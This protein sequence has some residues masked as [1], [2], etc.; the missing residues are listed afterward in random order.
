MYFNPEITVYILYGLVIVAILSIAWA[1]WLEIRLK[2]L[3]KGTNGKSLEGVINSNKK[4]LE[5]F[6]HAL[7]IFGPLK[8]YDWVSQIYS[9]RG[10]IYKNQGAFEKSKNDFLD[11]LRQSISENNV[12]PES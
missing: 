10:I 12:E 4:A 6:Q 11:K 2:K 9:W 7:N 1:I 3:L 8:R 5:K